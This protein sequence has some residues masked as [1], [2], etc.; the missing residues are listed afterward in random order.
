MKWNS[1]LAC[2][3][4]HSD[5]KTSLKCSR[6]FSKCLCYYI[7]ARSEYFHAIYIGH[8]W[9]FKMP[10]SCHTFIFFCFLLTRLA[11]EQSFPYLKI[12][13]GKQMV[14]CFLPRKVIFASGPYCNVPYASSWPLYLLLTLQLTRKYSS[15]LIQWAEG[16]RI[17]VSTGI[18]VWIACAPSNVHHLSCLELGRTFFIYYLPGSKLYYFYRICGNRVHT[19]R[20]C[21]PG[22]TCLHDLKFM[23]RN[24][25]IIEKCLRR[26]RCTQLCAFRFFFVF[27]FGFRE[28]ER[29]YIKKN[30]HTVYT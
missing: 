10:T 23:A 18:F 8:G 7:A 14:F 11:F 2:F 3:A 9:V 25:N 15:I 12:Y 19:C 4:F 5:S 24:W 21:Q 22:I 1:I 29:F 13:Q 17:V 20:P 27:F 16:R 26:K 30:A 28:I 6:T